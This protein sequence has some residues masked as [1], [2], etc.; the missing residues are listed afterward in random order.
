M[1]AY[2]DIL[3]QV[4]WVGTPGEHQKRGIAKALEFNEYAFFWEPGAGKTYATIHVAKTRY[5]WGQIDLVVIICPNSIKQVWDREVK[6]W[7]SDIPTYVQTLNAGDTPKRPRIGERTLE[8]LVI[9]VESLSA[10]KA[11]EKVIAYMQG[12]KAM[13]VEDESSRIKNPSS[14][15]TKKATNL[16][17]TGI[18]RLILTG[19]P[20]IQGP[21]D[22]FA[23][24]RF[25]NPNIIGIT[26]W[27]QFRARYCIMGGFEN[28]K[29]VKY[30]NIDE[31]T[32]RINPYA[33]L[34]ALKDCA[35][36]PEKIY[37]VINVPLSPEQRAVI[38]QLKDEGM[39][40]VEELGAELYV[41]MALERMT[42][43]QQIV[44][45][46]LPMID[47]ENGGYKTV[48]MQGRNPKMDAMFEYIEDL[49]HGTKCL[50]WARFEPER[51]R[52]V[53]R[54]VD[55]YGASAVVRFDGSVGDTDRIIAVDRIQ[56][57]PTCRFFVGNQTVAGIGLTLTAAKYAL[58][59]SNTFSSEDRI[60]M[61][62]R[63]HRKGQT[64]HC[65]YVD[66]EAMVKE[67]RMI[68]RAL[69]LKKDLAD[70]VK[71]SLS[72]K[73]RAYEHDPDM[74]GYL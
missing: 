59:F 74:E 28:K 9:A 22:L 8:F 30:Q 7:A 40:Q 24:F 4:P 33:D 1:S 57:D 45:G 17:W 42:R 39:I 73:N 70:L 31:L 63:N 16:A 41:E 61:E 18:Y 29:I 11:Y 72:Q 37:Q 26:K 6:Q 38:R 50:V 65:I 47:Q 12:R 34:V 55:V 58:N 64:D 23:Q 51:E 71:D 69:E 48:P 19:T 5:V 36:I 32:G 2:E 49:P 13:V 46:S 52:I 62:N 27:A 68:R 15:R 44:G 3:M 20:V 43:I 54:L 67:D 56:D 25:L 66:F 14:I 21:H 60:Q 35:D 53:Q 10:G